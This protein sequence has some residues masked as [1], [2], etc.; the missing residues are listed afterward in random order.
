M[1]VTCIYKNTTNNSSSTFIKIMGTPD[2][3]YAPMKNTD[4]EL[5]LFC[6]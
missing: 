6:H 4:V 5:V 1:R 3:F 2:I